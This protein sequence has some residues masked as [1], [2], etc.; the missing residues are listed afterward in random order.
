MLGPGAGVAKALGSVPLLAH[1]TVN[2]SL[3]SFSS[4]TVAVDASNSLSTTPCCRRGDDHTT[5]R[6]TSPHHTHTTHTHTHENEMRHNAQGGNILRSATSSSCNG[7]VL[8]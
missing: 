5:S 2:S 6:C 7:G 8:R 3:H 1:R 4:T